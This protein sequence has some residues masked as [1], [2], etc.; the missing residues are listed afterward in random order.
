MSSAPETPILA[1]PD[2][3]LRVPVGLSSPLWGFY[4]GAAVSGATWW[5][6][7]RWA[8][9]QNLEALFGQAVALEAP[10]AGM[11]VE[12]VPDAVA[13]PAA[14]PPAFVEPLDEGLEAAGEVIAEAIVE[15]PTLAEPVGGEAAPVAPVL[16][17]EAAPAP[18]PKKAGSPKAE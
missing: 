8:R 12:A 10:A 1:K 5:W 9:P 6:M 17:A 2:A 14:A 11:A 3:L 13:A 15:P 18:K 16:A 7:T 4:A